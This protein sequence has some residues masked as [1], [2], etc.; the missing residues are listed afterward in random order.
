ML[1]QA[2]V[3]ASNY[4]QSQKRRTGENAITHPLAIMIQLKRFS[5]SD[6]ILIPAVLHDIYEDTTATF[7]DVKKKFGKDVAQ[8]VHFLSKEEGSLFPKTS[9]GRLDRLKNYIQK[10]ETGLKKHPELLLIKLCDQIDNL[11]TFYIFPNEQ[12]NQKI[13]ELE[14]F[15]V[16]FY[17]KHKAN[18]PLPLKNT[19]SVLHQDFLQALEREEAAYGRAVE[20]DYF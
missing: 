1:T 8:M 20:G 3:F 4:Y 19:F 15:F 5:I 10:L 7:D 17:E 9:T 2:I 16:P 14:S 12:R 18:V 6:R 13:N 11:N